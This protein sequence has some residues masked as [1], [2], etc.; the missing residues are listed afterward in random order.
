MS[1]PLKTTF[2]IVCILI[3]LGTLVYAGILIYKRYTANSNTNPQT[4]TAD[5]STQT[6]IQTDNTPDKTETNTQSASE[7]NTSPQETVQTNISPPKPPKPDSNTDTSSKTSPFIPQTIP[8]ADKNAHIYI[9][10][11]K[12]SCENNCHQ[13]TKSTELQYCQE[14]C[15]L[16]S[17]SATDDCATL[18]SL[19][20][21][22]CF[23]AQ[24]IDKTD[25]TLCKKIADDN[26]RV[27]CKNRVLEDIVDQQK[28]Q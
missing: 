22:Y 18:K 27:A 11:S 10:L 16:V 21:D 23:K 1:S 17:S 28:S 6:P 15:G 20:Q 7:T 14:Y 12:V 9:P 2:K 26:I 3:A 13:F 25:P 19:D 5:T 8:S 4:S 24:A